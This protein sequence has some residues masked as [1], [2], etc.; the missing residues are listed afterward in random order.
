MK[1][2]KIKYKKAGLPPM[3]TFIDV[4]IVILTMLL[5]FAILYTLRTV[6]FSTTSLDKEACKTSVGIRSSA[7]SSFFKTEF[8]DVVPLRCKTE[9]ICLVSGN[10]AGCPELGKDYTKISVDGD[11]QKI[12]EAIG[13][14]IYEWH[15]TLGSGEL[16]FMPKGFTG[17]TYC[18]RNSLISFDN[19]TQNELK[20]KNIEISQ[21]DY[22]AWMFNKKTSDGK[23]YLE[24]LFNS[25]DLSVIAATRTILLNYSAPQMVVTQVIE[26]GSLGLLVS[27]LGGGTG[28]GVTAATLAVPGLGWF[29]GIRLAWAVFKVGAVTGAIGW[30]V[31]GPDPNNPLIYHYIP[32]SLMP[33]SEDTLE[34]LNCT[35][36]ETIS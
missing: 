9:K 18:F 31:F 14:N 6:I 29:K 2:G 19:N 8:R 20:K 24:V 11:K 7:S 27:A 30:K 21:Y 35:K 26:N 36:W 10:S 22:Y 5:I 1:L 3:E 28:L 4:A 17:R 16:N 23:S 32:P 12:L 34:G 13:Q 33:F 15:T 25:N